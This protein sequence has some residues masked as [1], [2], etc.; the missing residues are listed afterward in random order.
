M[1]APAQDASAAQAPMLLRPSLKKTHPDDKSLPRPAQTQAPARPA[2]ARGRRPAQQPR[3]ASLPASL[4]ETWRGHIQCYT[5]DQHRRRKSLQFDDQVSYAVIPP[6]LH[7]ALGDGNDKVT[8]DDDID[9][10]I[11]DA[12]TTN[13]LYYTAAEYASMKN[14]VR[15][16]ARRIRRLRRQEAAIHAD[17]GN[18]PA[19]L[20]KQH[21]QGVDEAQQAQDAENAN[22]EWEDDLNDW[23][24]EHRTC[25][26]TSRTLRAESVDRVVASVLAEQAAQSESQKKCT[27]LLRLTSRRASQVARSEA[28]DRG[29]MVERACGRLS[30]TDST[31]TSTQDFLP[32][33][34]EHRDNEAN[35]GDNDAT[36]EGFDTTLSASAPRRA[37]LLRRRSF[38]RRRRSSTSASSLTHTVDNDMM[39]RR[40]SM[41]RRTTPQDTPHVLDGSDISSNDG[42]ADDDNMMLVV[43]DASLDA[44]APRDL[45]RRGGSATTSSPLRNVSCA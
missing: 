14:A 39:G 43:A 16:D 7:L 30:S 28:L 6:A 41:L 31:T 19:Q 5:H 12:Q 34:D 9:N 25:P 29:R 11:D 10:D 42:S 15:T 20:L 2:K 24:I 18:S 44:S 35:D 27:I 33:N 22:D 8:A 36:D 13:T 38:L 23:G 17:A 26:P 4:D 21:L 32:S 37:L 40:D 1:E 45:R 3:S